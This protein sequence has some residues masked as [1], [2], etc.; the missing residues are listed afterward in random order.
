MFVLDFFEKEK[1]CKPELVELKNQYFK[2][3]E[4]ISPAKC[5]NCERKKLRDKYLSILLNNNYG[6]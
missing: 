1:D 6:F 2:E 3:L 4:E 5:K